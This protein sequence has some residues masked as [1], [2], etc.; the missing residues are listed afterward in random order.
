MIRVEASVVEGNDNEQTGILR[1]YCNPRRPRSGPGRKGIRVSSH[2]KG[3]GLA[4][5]A[6][7]R[8]VFIRGGLIPPLEGCGFTECFLCFLLFDAVSY[9]Y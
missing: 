7:G 6:L 9:F 2:K 1:V 3:E 4:S 5:S 8:S